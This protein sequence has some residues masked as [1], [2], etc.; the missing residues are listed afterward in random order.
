HDDVLHAI[1]FNCGRHCVGSA[2]L[3]STRIAAGGIGR[4]HYIDCFG[5]CESCGQRLLVCEIGDER[6]CSQGCELVQAICTSSQNAHFLS[7]FQKPGCCDVAG[8]P[9]CAGDDVHSCAS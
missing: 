9:S 8:V 6:F 1:L 5:A 2:V 4:D 3:I 7:A